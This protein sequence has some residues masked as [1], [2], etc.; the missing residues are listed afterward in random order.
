[1]YLQQ[2]KESKPRESIRITFKMRTDSFQF[3]W[4]SIL[5]SSKS[6]KKTDTR[7]DEK[8]YPLKLFVVVIIHQ[9]KYIISMFYW[10]TFCNKCLHS[11]HG[12]PL[13]QKS[14]AET[15][16]YPQ[17]WHFPGVGEYPA[18]VVQIF[19]LQVPQDLK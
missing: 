15:F 17:D 19:G 14:V 18:K 9:S 12:N 4:K 11:K 1:M 8:I 2:L 13:R 7:E 10:M 16:K 3:I 6:S 5:F